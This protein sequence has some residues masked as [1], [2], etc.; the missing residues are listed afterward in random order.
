MSWTSCAVAVLAVLAGTS[1]V[2][3]GTPDEAESLIQKGIELRRAHKDFEA[4]GYFRQALAVAQTPRAYAQIALAE[5]ALAHW[6]DAE[7]HLGAA[8]SVGDDSWIRKNRAVLE[9]SGAT[10]RSHIGQLELT[11][12]PEGARVR[13]NGSR[14]GRSRFQR[15]FT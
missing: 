1:Q 5:Q 11:G 12:E 2:Q 10:I 8:L 3:A 9:S 13:V 6:V 14:R 15:R 7:Q 4:L